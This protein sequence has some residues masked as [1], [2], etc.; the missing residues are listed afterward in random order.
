MF[1]DIW[2][3]KKDGSRGKNSKVEIFVIRKYEA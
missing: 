1:G 3:K 2:L